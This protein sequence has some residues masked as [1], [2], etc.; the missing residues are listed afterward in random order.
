MHDAA[1]W[2][3][4]QAAAAHALL[5]QHCRPAAPACRPWHVDEQMFATPQWEV[6]FT[7]DNDSDSTTEWREPGGRSHSVWTAPNSLLCVQVSGWRWG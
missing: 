3:R 4:R 6:I 2:G 1:R 7:V 5:R